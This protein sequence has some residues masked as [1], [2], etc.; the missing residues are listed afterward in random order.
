[1]LARHRRSAACAVLLTS[2]MCW[3]AMS[4]ELAVEPS[5][6]AETSTGPLIAREGLGK[7][8]AAHTVVGEVQ[9]TRPIANSAARFKADV[10]Y[11]AAGPS[12]M[13]GIGY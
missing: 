10:A 6:P 7:P 13:L 4:A 2:A 11:R 1:M 8:T 3:P 9:L 12:L 5:S